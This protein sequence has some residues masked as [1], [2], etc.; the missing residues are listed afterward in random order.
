M[1]VSMSKDKIFLILENLVHG[2]FIFIT[3][4]QDEKR[5]FIKNYR[6]SLTS[7][8]T[9][10]I[11]ETDYLAYKDNLVIETISEEDQKKI[12]KTIQGLCQ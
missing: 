8:N 1:K 4:G 12:G 9:G 6:D 7:L 2:D 11:W 10:G 3:W 5:L